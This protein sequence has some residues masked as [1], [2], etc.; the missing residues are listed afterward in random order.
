[1][2][3]FVLFSPVVLSLLILMIVDLRK[4]NDPPG[5]VKRKK[6]A[7]YFLG[8]QVFDGCRTDE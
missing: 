2:S 1:M 4:V 8:S 7:G 6:E 5:I 3:Q